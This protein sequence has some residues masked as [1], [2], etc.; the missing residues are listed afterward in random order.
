M[1]ELH[2]RPERVLFCVLA[3]SQGLVLHGGAGMS[4]TSPTT[5]RAVDARE[6]GILLAELVGLSQ[7]LTKQRVYK[8]ARDGVLPC[9]RLGRVVRFQTQQLESF[10]ASGG[11]SVPSRGGGK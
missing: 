9:V 11:M 3:L 7:P 2:P 6:A 8:L 4:V 10:V 1:A 5:G